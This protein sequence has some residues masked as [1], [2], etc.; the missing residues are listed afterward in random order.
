MG[1]RF[2]LQSIANN[3]Y[4]TQFT[5]PGLLVYVRK[6]KFCIKK[7]YIEYFKSLKQKG[8]VSPW[9]YVAYLCHFF[10]LCITLLLAKSVSLSDIEHVRQDRGDQ[11]S[12]YIKEV[13]M[14]EIISDVKEK[15]KTF[16]LF[17][18][19]LERFNFTV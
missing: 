15:R 13:I 7:C 3:F 18:S 19:N 17:I 11:F 9:K 10:K 4:R 12:K 6:I 2:K 16:V 14:K 8:V 1:I 5:P